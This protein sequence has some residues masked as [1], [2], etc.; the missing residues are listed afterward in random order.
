[1]TESLYS[2]QTPIFA[3]QKTSSFYSFESFAFNLYS[4]RMSANS[5]EILGKGTIDKI[6][7]IVSDELLSNRLIYSGY[8]NEILNDHLVFSTYSEEINIQ[9]VI[10]SYIKKMRRRPHPRVIN[11]L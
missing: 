9:R 8:V 4:G 2:V 10:D 7:S 6:S 5:T 1:M 3:N 11:R